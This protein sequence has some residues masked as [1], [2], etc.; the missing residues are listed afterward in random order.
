MLEISG[1]STGAGVHS[2][3][4]IRGLFFVKDDNVGYLIKGDNLAFISFDTRRL[5]HCK[6]S[7]TVYHSHHLSISGRMTPSME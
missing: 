4:V 5:M 7:A 6:V 2:H 1:G 3:Q